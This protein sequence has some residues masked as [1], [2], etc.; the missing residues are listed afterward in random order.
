MGE[1][2]CAPSTTRPL[3]AP[4]LPSLR[5]TDELTQGLLAQSAISICRDLEASQG[6][7]SGD[8]DCGGSAG[9]SPPGVSG[10]D[11]AG[12]GSSSEGGDS[13]GAGG[14]PRLGHRCFRVA[15]AGIGTAAA[16][17]VRGSCATRAAWASAAAHRTRPQLCEQQDWGEGSFL[18]R[19]V[20]DRSL[21]SA[22]GS[23]AG[24][25]AA[26]AGSEAEM[27]VGD[28]PHLPLCTLFWSAAWPVASFTSA[29]AAA[30]SR[31]ST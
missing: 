21:A 13:G 25:T 12:V 31:T 2:A 6:G 9:G 17:E 28:V 30:G 7:D 16:R 1:D 26:S 11:Y 29:T 3:F 20:T 4:L 5:P 10:S 14:S 23:E 27:E 19:R 18:E 15:I 22:R 8:G 24:V